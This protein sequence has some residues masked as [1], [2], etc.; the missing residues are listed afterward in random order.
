MFLEKEQVS[1]LLSWLRFPCAEGAPGQE[2][3][4]VDAGGSCV[5][6]SSFLPSGADC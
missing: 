6:P 1:E 2:G 4:G 5:L 3:Q